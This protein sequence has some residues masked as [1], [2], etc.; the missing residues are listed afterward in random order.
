MN[1]TEFDT[2]HVAGAAVQEVLGMLVQP[3]YYVRESMAAAA[4]EP[5]PAPPA[6]ETFDNWGSE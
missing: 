2:L 3:P 6:P 4:S 1:K 5:E